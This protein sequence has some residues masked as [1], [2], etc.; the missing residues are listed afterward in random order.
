MWIGWRK[1]G[2]IYRI[3]MAKTVGEKATWNINNSL[4]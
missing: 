2:N 1:T 3:L 4:Y